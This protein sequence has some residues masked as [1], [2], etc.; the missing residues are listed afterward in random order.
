MN[1]WFWENDRDT[2]DAFISGGWPLDEYPNSFLTGDIVDIPT[3]P[4]EITMDEESQGRLT[5]NLLLTGPAKIFSDKLIKILTENGVD[6]IQIFPCKIINLVSNECFNN[7]KVVNVIWKIKCVDF[8]NSSVASITENEQ[9][10]FAWDYLTL[11]EKKIHNFKMFVLS[12]MP[13]QL[14]VH[15]SI[16]NILKENNITGVNFIPQGEYGYGYDFE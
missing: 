1:Y 3:S 12:E 8:P 10:F 14:V 16:Q 15:N 13:S 9:Q 11:D 4:I 7:Y 5:D 6:N 2:D